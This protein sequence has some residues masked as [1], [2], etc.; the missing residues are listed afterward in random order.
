MYPSCLTCSVIKNIIIRTNKTNFYYTRQ[1]SRI[2]HSSFIRS[3]LNL[4]EQ[5]IAN[6]TMYILCMH[7]HIK[8]VRIHTLSTGTTISKTV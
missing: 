1:T 6:S 8:T 5:D 2:S 3:F 4:V 7:L